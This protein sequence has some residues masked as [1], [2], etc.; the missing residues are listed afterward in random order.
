MFRLKTSA[1]KTTWAH[2]KDQTSHVRSHHEG[3]PMNSHPDAYFNA[4][5]GQLEIQITALVEPI[6]WCWCNSP[7]SLGESIDKGHPFGRAEFLGV[8]HFDASGA[9]L[10]GFIDF[11]LSPPVSTCLHLDLPWFIHQLILLNRWAAA[12]RDFLMVEPSERWELGCG[13]PDKPW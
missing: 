5:F 1:G 12:N 6:W 7:I 11:Y 10:L 3:I 8:A 9:H 2:W 4:L 13:K